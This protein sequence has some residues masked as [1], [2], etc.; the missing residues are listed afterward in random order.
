MGAG[1]QDIPSALGYRK[2]SVNV[3]EAAFKVRIY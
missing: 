1:V 2:Y 3:V